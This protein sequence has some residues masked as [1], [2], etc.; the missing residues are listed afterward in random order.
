MLQLVDKSIISIIEMLA[1]PGNSLVK[2]GQMSDKVTLLR[3]ILMEMKD[4]QGYTVYS[5][6]N[7]LVELH[8]LCSH[9][10]DQVIT[11]HANSLFWPHNVFFVVVTK[12][13][14]F[15]SF[16]FVL[17][18]SFSGTETNTIQ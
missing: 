11:L 9:L 5:I 7:N 14:D 3:P 17:L 1:R 13:F 8:R 4:N 16:L 10:L 12:V 2:C 15:E 18:E 6:L